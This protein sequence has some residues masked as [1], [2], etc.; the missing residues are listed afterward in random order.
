MEKRLGLTREKRCE[1]CKWHEDFSW[2]YVNGE[3]P[4]VADFTDNDDWCSEW[5]KRE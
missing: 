2:A 4:K 3:S 5:E 1:N